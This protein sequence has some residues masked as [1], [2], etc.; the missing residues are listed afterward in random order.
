MHISSAYTVTSTMM[1]TADRV[2]QEDEQA[3]VKNQ[4]GRK[5]CA[6]RQVQ[7]LMPLLLLLLL[8]LLLLPLLPLLLLLA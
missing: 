5:T 3:Q 1:P 6:A 4:L 2:V 7:S 8:P